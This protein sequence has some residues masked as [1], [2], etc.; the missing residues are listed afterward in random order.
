MLIPAGSKPIQEITH[1]E[2]Q[3]DLRYQGQYLDRETGLHYNTFRYYDPDTGRFTQPDPIGLIR[4]VRKTGI[5]NNMLGFP[6]TR[7]TILFRSN[8]EIIN[9]F[10]ELAQI[11]IQAIKLFICRLRRMSILLEQF[12]EDLILIIQN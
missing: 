4:G 11:F 7:S 10:K 6:V 2:I 5:Y 9:C 12:T 3:Q 1:R 8:Y